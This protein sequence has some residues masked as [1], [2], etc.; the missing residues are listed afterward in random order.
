MELNA[1][2]KKAKAKASQKKYIVPRNACVA[3][4]LGLCMGMHSNHQLLTFSQNGVK[5]HIGVIKGQ[6]T[7][8]TYES[9]VS[10]SFDQVWC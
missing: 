2:A 9:W 4:R 3:C 6:P 10:G 5:G 8:I 1:T 7:Y